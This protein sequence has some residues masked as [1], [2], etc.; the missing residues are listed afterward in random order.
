MGQLFQAGLDLLQAGEDLDVVTAG[1]GFGV[2]VEQGQGG[3]LG[4]GELLLGTAELDR[5]SVV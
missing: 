4:V 2:L 1:L 5:K 3:D